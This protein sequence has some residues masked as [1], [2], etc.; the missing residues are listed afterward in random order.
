MT[1][2]KRHGGSGLQSTAQ[3]NSKN[4]DQ[5]NSDDAKLGA[6]ESTVLKSDSAEPIAEG[7]AENKE[8]AEAKPEAVADEE[9]A[10][11]PV[12]EEAAENKDEAEEALGEKADEP[13]P[14]GGK[15]EGS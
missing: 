14:D 9:K 12:G 4:G 1:K 6:E 13:G 3:G 11:E 8:E 2:K 15:S 7:A 5:Q 10:E